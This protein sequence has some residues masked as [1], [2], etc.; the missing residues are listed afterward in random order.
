VIEVAFVQQALAI[1]ILVVGHGQHLGVV[2][3]EFHA[4]IVIDFEVGQ[5]RARQLAGGFA[6]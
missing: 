3:V 2:A 5:V 1:K 4:D 6:Q